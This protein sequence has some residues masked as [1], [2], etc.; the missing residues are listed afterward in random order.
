MKRDGGGGHLKKYTASRFE[1]QTQRDIEG[2]VRKSKSKPEGYGL[3]RVLEV[4]LERH[5]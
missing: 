1:V 5:T 4:S 3:G 2:S